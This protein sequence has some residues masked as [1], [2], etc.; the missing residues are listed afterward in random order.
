M[1]VFVENP[2]DVHPSAILGHLS[3]LL[4]QKETLVISKNAK[5]RSGCVL[6][7]GTKIGESLELGHNVVIRERNVIGH[8]VSIWSN[9]VVDYGCVIGNN[10]KIHCNCYIAQYSVIE[11]NAFLAPGV[12]LAN[13]LYPG[14]EESKQRMKGPLIRRGAQIGVNATI[15]PFV[16]IGEEAIVGAGSVVTKNVP[17]R[18]I[19]VG[20]P[21]R[22][23]KQEYKK[24]D[25]VE[26]LKRRLI[27][28][29]QAR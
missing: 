5:I 9:S 18:S 19:V 1:S 11:D 28:L 14:I 7:L 15:L 13:D 27:Q 25:L 26:S 3:P 22:V 24:E 21:A 29:D 6:Y 2:C 17:R 23:I 4:K 12:V 8:H 16:E 10:V 20:N